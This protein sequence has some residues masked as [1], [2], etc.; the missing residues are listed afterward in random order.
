MLMLA[1]RAPIPGRGWSCLVCGLPADG[2][3]SV[4]CDACLDPEVSKGGAPLKY[5]CRGY[6]A[7]DGRVPIEALS[8]PFEHDRAHSCA[9]TGHPEGDFWPEGE[10]GD[11]NPA[12]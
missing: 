9:R 11:D 8:E 2:A 1:K 10:D 6:P 12:R 4:L 7:H 5:A 3:V